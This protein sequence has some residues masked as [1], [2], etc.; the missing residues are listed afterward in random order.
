[1]NRAAIVAA[2]EAFFKEHDALDDVSAFSHETDLI[3]AGIMD[4][5]LL[6]TLVGFCEERFDCTLEP[7]ELTEDNFRS[8]DKIAAYIES[9]IA[10]S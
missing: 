6:V 5:L 2:L 8:L 1:M 7:H 9:K 10:R 4:S 3:E